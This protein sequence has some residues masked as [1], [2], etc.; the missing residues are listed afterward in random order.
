MHS[1]E[2]IFNSKENGEHHM[3]QKPDRLIGFT[4]FIGITNYTIG[5]YLFT[6]LANFISF[7]DLTEWTS[8]TKYAD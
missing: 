4:E 6:R 7:A 8:F 5:H 1:Q 3:Q 2:N